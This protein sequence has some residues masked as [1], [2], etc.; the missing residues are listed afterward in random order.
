MHYTKLIKLA[1]AFSKRAQ[2]IALDSSD[3]VTQKDMD[4][5]LS[6][7][8]VLQDAASTIFEWVSEIAVNT[9]DP[10]LMELKRFSQ[11]LNDST[12]NLN[13]NASTFIEST[14]ANKTISTMDSDV[15]AVTQNYNAI[16]DT[17]LKDDWVAKNNQFDEA[18]AMDQI[19]ESM[20]FIKKFIQK[21][22]NSEANSESEPSLP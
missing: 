2:V 9:N 19:P 12:K 4:L 11:A 21:Q 7:S 17:Y 18:K 1:W 22:R 10:R 13:S 20:S 8:Q 6:Q 3:A 15:N 16:H 5:F 14:D